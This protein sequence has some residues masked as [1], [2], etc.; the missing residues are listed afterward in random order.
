MHMSGPTA[1]ELVRSM[2]RLPFGVGVAG[3]SLAELQTGEA[4]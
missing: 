3:L 1:L 4:E 2:V